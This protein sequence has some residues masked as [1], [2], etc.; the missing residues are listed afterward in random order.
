MLDRTM[1]DLLDALSSARP[2]PAGGA[3]VVAAGAAG[4]A[5]GLK[6]VRISRKRAKEGDAAGLDAAEA[7]LARVLA[8]LPPR[9]DEDC[10]AFESVLAARRDRTRDRAA[11]WRR[12]TEVPLLVAGLARDGL[13]AL[14][15]VR[16]SVRS[17]VRC[18]LVAAATLLHAAARISS[19]NAAANAPAVGAAGRPLAESAQAAENG[20]TRSLDAIR[21]AGEPR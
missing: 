4:A 8:E 20:A 15:S 18:D 7:E 13:R 1:R 12:A 17:A 2:L 3:A 6:V 14:E 11:A 21:A 16:G 10:D 9:F 5:L 19:L